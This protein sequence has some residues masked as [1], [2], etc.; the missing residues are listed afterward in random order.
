MFL[1]SEG[2]RKIGV[3]MGK[4]ARLFDAYWNERFVVPLGG[5]TARPTCSSGKG[6][7]EA[8]AKDH[9]ILAKLDLAEDAI[10]ACRD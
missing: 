8:T 6:W 1:N 5:T 10:S 4:K 2:G 9:K 7:R 3:R